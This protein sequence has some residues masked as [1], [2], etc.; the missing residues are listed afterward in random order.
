MAQIMSYEFTF[1]CALFAFCNETFFSRLLLFT[2][3][4]LICSLIFDIL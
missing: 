1:E 3:D 2:R 4:V